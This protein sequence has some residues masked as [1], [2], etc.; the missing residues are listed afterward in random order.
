[1]TIKE[2]ST[3]KYIG[4]YLLAVLPYNLIS[5]IFVSLSAEAML[6]NLSIAIIITI[7]DLAIWCGIFIYVYSK[8]D[9]ID[10]N[11][12]M[13]WIAGLI[14]IGIIYVFVIFQSLHFL[15]YYNFMLFLGIAEP[16]AF[17]YIFYNHFKTKT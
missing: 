4:V 10:V 5:T 13:P 9:D 2:A 15:E 3:L 7:I 1:M 11:K 16:I 14:V 12:A 8:F 6:A 17:L